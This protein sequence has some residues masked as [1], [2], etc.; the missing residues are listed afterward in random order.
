MIFSWQELPKRAVLAPLAGR[1]KVM[2]ELF[3]E[4]VQ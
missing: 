1:A 2:D 4:N 3:S